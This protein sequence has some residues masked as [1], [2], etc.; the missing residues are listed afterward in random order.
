MKEKRLHEFEPVGLERT[1]QLPQHARDI[2]PTASLEKLHGNARAFKPIDERR[3]IAIRPATETIDH[4]REPR[5]IQPRRQLDQAPLRAA[6]M[7]FG[8]AES[9]SERWILANSWHARGSKQRNY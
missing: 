3:G 7:Q 2:S 6:D 5:T 4:R 1:A 8:D 9:D